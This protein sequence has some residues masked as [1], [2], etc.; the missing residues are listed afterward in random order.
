MRLEIRK[1]EVFMSLSGYLSDTRNLSFNV[2]NKL[3]GTAKKTKKK[4]MK[5]NHLGSITLS[6]RR[7]WRNEKLV[8]EES[9]AVCWKMLFVKSFR[10]KMLAIVWSTKDWIPI[11]QYAFN[12]HRKNSL[13]TNWAFCFGKVIRTLFYTRTLSSLVYLF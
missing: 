4:I 1:I 10:M 5:D 2:A 13:R 9:V 8:S 11:H 3:A 7:K 12:S 6:W